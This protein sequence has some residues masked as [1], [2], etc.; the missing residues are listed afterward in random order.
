MAEFTTRP[1]ILGTFG[2]VTSTHGLATA[3]GMATLER[4][5]NAFD[6]AVAAGFALQVVEPHRNGPGG[7]LPIILYSARTDAVEV[8]CGQG[9]APQAA[10]VAGY[11][12]LGL[13]LVPGNGLSGADRGGAVRLVSRLRRRGDRALLSMQRGPGRD[14]PAASRAAR[15]RRSGALAGHGRAAADL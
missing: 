6:A 7:D 4:G 9:G 5:G 1:E 10:T 3:T 12:Q 13:D 14:G 11:R 15:G 2:V 8:I